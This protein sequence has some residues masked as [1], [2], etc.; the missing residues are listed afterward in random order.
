MLKAENAFCVLL[1]SDK[2]KL[3]GNLIPNRELEKCICFKTHRH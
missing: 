1:L 3:L 2:T